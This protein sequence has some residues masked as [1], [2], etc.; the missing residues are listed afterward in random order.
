MFTASLW[1]TRWVSLSCEFGTCGVGPNAAI[2]D[3]PNHPYGTSHDPTGGLGLDSALK[4]GA[5]TLW[6]TLKYTSPAYWLT[7]CRVVNGIADHPVKVGVPLGIAGLGVIGK[8]PTPV[9]IGIGAYGSIYVPI[10]HE[11]YCGVKK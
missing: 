4:I 2:G 1:E 6:Q 7:S 9:T 11:T 3:D 8:I 5:I 10:A